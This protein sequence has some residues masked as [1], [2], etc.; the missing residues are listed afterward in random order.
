MLCTLTLDRTEHQNHFCPPVHGHTQCGQFNCKFGV[1]AWSVCLCNCVS[2]PC[3]ISLYYQSLYC[4]YFHKWVYVDTAV[5]YIPEFCQNDYDY[6]RSGLQLQQEKTEEG[7]AYLWPEGCGTHNTQKCM[8]VIIEP[9]K[10]TKHQ[11]IR[12]LLTNSG[13]FKVELVL[14]G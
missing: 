8:G 2:V 11:C 13:L 3:M 14:E 7:G 1:S 9:L 5:T 10:L 6:E 12:E 4:L